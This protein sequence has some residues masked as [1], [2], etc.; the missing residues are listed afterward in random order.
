MTK[1]H[2]RSRAAWLNLCREVRHWLFSH[3]ES[4]GI[5]IRE[6]LGPC[7]C[8]GTLDTLA[9]NGLLRRK[10]LNGREVYS[11]LPMG[12]M[13]EWQIQQ[14]AKTLPHPDKIL[15]ENEG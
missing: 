5:Q 9:S 11:T 2:H 4:T 10:R 13:P 12:E 1:R 8:K 6:G 14:W 7:Y 15:S 3:P